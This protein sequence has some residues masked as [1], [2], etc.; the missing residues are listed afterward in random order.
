VTG[1]KPRRSARLAA[2]DLLARREHARAEL[3]DKLLARDFPAD[4]V[5]AALE[6]LAAEGLQSD[7]RF[8]EAFV[9][10]RLGR[11]QGPLRILAELRQRAVAP[12][13]VDG[14]LAGAG[15]DWT[16][17]ARA[18]RERR[19][20]PGCPA[21]WA[22]RARQARFLAQRGFSSEQVRGALGADDDN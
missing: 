8:V 20:G 10:S 18:A 2:M 6:A 7:A 1:A 14:A 4:E 19:F 9:R 15:V 5:A 16:A 3:R 21:D 12:E 22:E 17:L 11:G 13:L